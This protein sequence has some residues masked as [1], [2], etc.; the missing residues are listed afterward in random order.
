M[1]QHEILALAATVGATVDVQFTADRPFDF[2]VAKTTNSRKYELARTRSKPV[3]TASW[4]RDSARGGELL[5]LAGDG[6]GNAVMARERGYSL[7]AFAGLCV[8][9]T[10]YSQ[11]ARAEMGAQ[12]VARGG[13]YTSDLVKNRCTHLVAFNSTSSK[14]KHASKWDGVHVVSRAWVEE[15]IASEQR[16]DEA[17]F[18]VLAGGGGGSGATT[19][20][21]AAATGP[22]SGIGEDQ[23]TTDA[24]VPW[25][26]C[27]MMETKVH[28]FD[29]GP[30]RASAESAAVTRLVRRL[31]API[32]PH[33]GKATHIVVSAMAAPGS[34]RSLREHR[35]RV[36][37]TSWLDACATEGAPAAT[38][39]HAA[40][41]HLF[42]GGGGGGRAG[43][44][45]GAGMMLRP[46]SGNNLASMIGGG[47]LLGRADGG[48]NLSQEAASQ[49]PQRAGGNGRSRFRLGTA[50]HA[51]AAAAAPP[52]AAELRHRDGSDSLNPLTRQALAATAA[53]ETAAEAAAAG[54]AA[55]ADKAAAR[56]AAAAAAAAAEEADQ[57][58]PPCGQHQRRIQSPAAV[59]AMAMAAG[60]AGCSYEPATGTELPATAFAIPETH[61]FFGRGH[62]LEG[63]D[64]GGLGGGE[65]PPFD[66]VR[67]ALSP[68]LSREEEDAARD[69]IASGGGIAV[70]IPNTAGGG[71]ASAGG[72]GGHRGSHQSTAATSAAYIVC[73]A[74]PTPQE[75][76]TLDAAPE[77]E[78]RRHVT[79][80]W[81]EMS[82]QMGLA[83]PL[84]SGGE[85]GGN[86]A[87]RPLPCDAPVESMQGLRISTSLYDE[88][89]KASV[90]MLCHLLGA[91]YTDRLGRNKN[92][93]LVVPVAEG[94]K[95][96]AATGWGLQVVTVEWLHACV[97]AGRK[98]DEGEFAPPPPPEEEE[99]EGED[100]VADFGEQRE[101]KAVPP[102][103]CPQRED[104][105]PK[106]PSAS[107]AGIGEQR[108]RKQ[109]Q[110]QG[111]DRA[112]AA[113][114]ATARGHTERGAAAGLGLTCAAAGTVDDRTAAGGP[115]RRSAEGGSDGGG[116]GTE[117][118]ER[119]ALKPVGRIGTRDLSHVLQA[120]QP[121]QAH[122][123]QAQVQ[124]TLQAA[125]AAAPSQPSLRTNA[126]KGI[127][128]RAGGA[129]PSAR[130]GR[131]SVD[132]AAALAGAGSCPADKTHRWDAHPSEGEAPQVG[133]DETTQEPG[134][135][136][137]PLPT[138]EE[139]EEVAA[140]APAP[141]S[142]A[143]LARG[144][145]HSTQQLHD[146][147]QFVAN[148]IDDV[149]A[150]MMGAGVSQLD[151]MHDGFD[152]FRV[153]DPVQ[154]A[155]AVAAGVGHGHGPGDAQDRGGGGASARKRR[156]GAGGG[157]GE[158]AVSG[159]T[160]GG[161]GGLLLSQADVESQQLVGY[162]EEG[163]PTRSTRNRGEGGG[164]GGGGGGGAGGGGGV[165]AGS[166]GGGASGLVDT[167]LGAAGGGGGDGTARKGGRGASHSSGRAAGLQAEDWV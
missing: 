135:W 49:D 1:A 36:V 31:A 103:L 143:V 39:D 157:G 54:L 19:D 105:Q 60:D 93:H 106:G 76:R 91:R 14:Y 133:S 101:D 16:A 124:A 52:A 7:P 123:Q 33:P 126:D 122:A 22:T 84:T 48:V 58:R 9:V 139:E 20:T 108:R 27:C 166:V 114:T 97:A 82:V 45:A 120:S 88:C 99:E 156:R 164:L 162:A 148:L 51:I 102:L 152:G 111:S 80:H 141:A 109:Q 150:G 110:Q 165:G 79:C 64:E 56:A 115:R 71:A 90:H 140:A 38:E 3:V 44:A 40:P 65:V 125:T 144:T 127:R 89:V 66:G 2:C 87:Y 155:A 83:I 63:G 67:I 34:L 151:T 46:A 95:F 119:G 37:L 85:G 11:D 55:T 161:G 72:G 77:A 167:L 96:K 30:P 50:S 12:V 35:A 160:G 43:A 53:A 116:G 15:C 78:R 131:R 28:L 13:V 47:G 59:R 98:V 24:A 8:C 117:G 75:R 145:T 138:E 70:T 23:E 25:E 107:G 57:N 134:G 118:K 4:L 17:R 154:A 94:A 112:G 128:G 69:C 41:G 163:P 92:T 29:L 130:P 121:C 61:P 149:A 73:P 74:A 137:N 6:G 81:L 132:D 5:P 129:A 10:G 68:L 42:S 26:E 136:R 18:P 104:A 100:I 147:S 32:T 21:A 153:P 113:S 86:P 146:G 142:T 62:A 158:V 159:V